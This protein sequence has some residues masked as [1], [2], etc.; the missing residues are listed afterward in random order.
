MSAFDNAL[1]DRVREVFEAYDEP[2]DPAALARM[3]TALGHAPPVALDRAPVARHSRTRR[4]AWVALAALMVAGGVWL[5][6]HSGAPD[7][8]PVAT[9]ETV[10]SSEVSPDARPT[11]ADLGDLPLASTTPSTP[12]TGPST[13]RA[14]EANSAEFVEAT[15]A[16]ATRS[17]IAPPHG[18][19]SAPSGAASGSGRGATGQAVARPDTA[20]IPAPTG[21]ASDPVAVTGA[22]LSD[23]A[24]ARAQGSSEVRDPARGAEAVEIEPRPEIA[25]MPAAPNR[26][27]LP[28]LGSTG[29]GPEPIDVGSPS[30]VSSPYRIA[31]STSA[32][33]AVADGIGVAGGVTRSWPVAGRLSVSGG[34][35]MAYNRYDIDSASA[36]DAAAL[37]LSPGRSIEVVSRT[38]AETVA[39]EIPLDLAFDVAGTR[40][41][42]LAVSVGVTSA[43]YL[44]QSFR[45][46]RTRYS[47]DFQAGGASGDPNSESYNTQSA[48]GVLSRVELARQLN[49]GV[50]VA[51]RRGL[52]AELY[53]RLPLGGLTDRDLGLA[54]VGVRLRVPFR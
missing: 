1:A 30:D 39:L 4:G 53:T 28:A 2:V 34:A 38:Q 12:Q 44:S 3:K 37:D 41:V 21:V 19:S 29:P 11:G 22:S 42:R 25:A 9:A 23:A 10:R 16:E 33:L 48:E 51:R 20:P 45:D 15:R 52:S 26:S 5:H 36:F 24:S 7:L 35:L 40:R 47:S 50:Q 6:T 49:L 18:P 46:E 54:S 31:F 27:I 13:P 14:P 8:E 32:P 43:V 17:D